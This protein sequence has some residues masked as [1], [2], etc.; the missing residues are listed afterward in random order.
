NENSR[1]SSILQES[2]YIVR[3]ENCMVHEALKEFDDS[4]LEDIVYCSGD[5]SRIRILNPNFVLTRTCTLMN[6][7]YC[8]ACVHDSRIVQEF[9][10]PTR[11]FY[12]SM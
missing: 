3:V 1:M 11:K 7:P 2:K 12:D 5:F 8:D 9:E 10:H 4:E 6:G